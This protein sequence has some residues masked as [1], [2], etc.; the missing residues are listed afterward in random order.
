[1]L[2]EADLF[3]TAKFEDAPAVLTFESTRSEDRKKSC[4]IRA[5]EISAS[6][7][8][9]KDGT[10]AAGRDLQAS[11]FLPNEPNSWCADG[12]TCRSGEFILLMA[13]KERMFAIWHPLRCPRENLMFTANGS[14]K[15]T[16]LEITGG[17]ADNFN[18]VRS[19]LHPLALFKILTIS[20]YD[21]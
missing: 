15:S 3:N 4:Y 14:G 5:S 8:S 6:R 17:A 18:P 13:L 9:R 10:S 12:G 16:L 2:E 7:C 19:T 20:W 1:M 11:R 21:C